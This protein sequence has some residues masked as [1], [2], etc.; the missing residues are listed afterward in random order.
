MTRQVLKLQDS[1]RRFIVTFKEGQPRNPYTLYELTWDMGEHRRQIVK[2]Q[3]LESCLY[4]L[5]QSGLFKN[6]YFPA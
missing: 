3:N 6:D 2:Y 4:H 1:G 5:A